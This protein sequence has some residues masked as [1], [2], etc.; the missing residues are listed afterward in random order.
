MRNELSKLVQEFIT[1]QGLDNLAKIGNFKQANIQKQSDYYD[2]RK[3]SPEL[4]ASSNRLKS[5]YQDIGSLVMYNWVYLTV[6]ILGK[7]NY[8]DNNEWNNDTLKKHIPEL[9]AMC[10]PNTLE[11]SSPATLAILLQRKCQ[12]RELV[13]FY[14]SDFYEWDQ[15]AELVIIHHCIH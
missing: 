11:M 15:I 5:H 9:C 10:T 4:I 14:E 7:L 12:A 13:D 3:M 6:A 8:R 2:Y 1:L